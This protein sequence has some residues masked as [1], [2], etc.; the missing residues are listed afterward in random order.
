MINFASERK[1]MFKQNYENK[2]KSLMKWIGDTEHVQHFMFEVRDG[3][4]RLV[5]YYKDDTI[6]H[7]IEAE[8]EWRLVY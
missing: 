3:R 6:N 4:N 7:V 8:D 2:Y 1:I 5:I